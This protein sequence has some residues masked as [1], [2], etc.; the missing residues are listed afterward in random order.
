MTDSPSSALAHLA[1]VI[2]AYRRAALEKW[3]QKLGSSATYNNLIG[4]FELA[5]YSGYANTVRNII[6]GMC[7][8]RYCSQSLI[9][10]VVLSTAEPESDLQPP[11]S[12]RLCTSTHVGSDEMEGGN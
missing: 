10:I 9:I 3:K 7:I 8:I 4:V 1:T 5:D 6:F 11:A 2:S 12:K